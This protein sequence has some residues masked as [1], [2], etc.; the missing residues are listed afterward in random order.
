MSTSTAIENDT[1]SEFD[2]GASAPVD[3]GFSGGASVWWTWI[4]LL[5]WIPNLRLLMSE[6]VTFFTIAQTMIWR[7]RIS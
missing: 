5:T 3:F 4:A 7:S 1:P 6:G 2:D